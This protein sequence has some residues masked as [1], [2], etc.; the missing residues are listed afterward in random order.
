MIDKNVA[1]DDASYNEGRAAF[2]AG[3]SVR[4]IVEAVLGSDTDRD[5]KVAMSGALGFVDAALDR[6]RTPVVVVQ[7]NPVGI[8]ERKLRG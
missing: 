2:E 8:V 5:F 3:A 7:N 4:S 6:L 1:I